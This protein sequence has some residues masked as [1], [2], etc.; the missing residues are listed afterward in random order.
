[1]KKRK[2]VQRI[3]ML[4]GVFLVGIIINSL[5]SE[6]GLSSVVLDDKTFEKELDTSLWN[7]PDEDVLIQGGS[8]LFPKSSTES[9]RLITKTTA[10][11][12]M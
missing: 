9:T 7:N 11:Q 5:H 12:N 10:K 2:K 6:A 8:L 3:G 4:L 1:M